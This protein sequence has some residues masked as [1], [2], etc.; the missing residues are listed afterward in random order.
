MPNFPT[1][2]QA[3]HGHTKENPYLVLDYPYSFRLRCQLRAWLETSPTHGTRYV[4]QTSNPKKPGLVWNKPKA[5]TY[6]LIAGAM[7]LDSVG[8]VQ[9]YGLGRWSGH[10]ECAAFLEHWPEHGKL[11]APWVVAQIAY[12]QKHAFGDVAAWMEIARKLKETG[13]LK[14]GLKETLANAFAAR[15]LSAARVVVDRL[16]TKGLGNAPPFDY[17]DLFAFAGRAI[18]G[19]ERATW[20]AFLGQID[21]AES[22]AE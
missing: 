9:W 13:A 6:A 8:H 15:N 11:I 3:L 12:N 18:P 21:E 1:I 20:D 22:A 2:S 16:R 7:Y 10:E 17:A 4:T 14:P 19:I 5:S